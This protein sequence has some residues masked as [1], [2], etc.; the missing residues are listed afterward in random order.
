[1]D[2]ID[3]GVSPPVKRLTLGRGLH[4]IQIVNPNFPDHVLTVDSGS[5]ESATIQHDFTAQTK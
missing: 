5:Q 2:G 4:T 3:R 1:V